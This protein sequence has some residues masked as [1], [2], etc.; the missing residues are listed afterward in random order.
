M[1]KKLSG[2]HSR[3]VSSTSDS[4]VPVF[5]RGQRGKKIHHTAKE[6]WCRHAA[7]PIIIKRSRC[8]VRGSSESRIAPSS[9]PV[10]PRDYKFCARPNDTSLSEPRT[11]LY[12]W[13]PLGGR[14][15]VLRWSENRGRSDPRVPW[16]IDLVRRVNEHG[17]PPRVGVL[18]KKIIDLLF[19]K[20]SRLIVTSH[21]LANEILYKFYIKNIF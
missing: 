17:G 7:H 16:W 3:R 12:S 19:E 1:A 9:P 2:R 15:R 14:T 4:L 21:L 18:A 13:F 11:R 6:T 5:V 10:V 8:W 20:F